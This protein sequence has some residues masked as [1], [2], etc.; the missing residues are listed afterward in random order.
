M[1]Y[2][3]HL[4]SVYLSIYLFVCLSLFL[5]LSVYVCLSLYLSTPPVKV[6]QTAAQELDAR[7]LMFGPL[8]SGGA[9]L[10]GPPRS[11]GWRSSRV[12]W[13]QMVGN[14][15]QGRRI[16]GLLLGPDEAAPDCRVG[17]Q[18]CARCRTGRRNGV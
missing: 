8:A 5:S 14:A 12:S 17:C 1:L 2:I 15:A 18:I 3:E 7:L 10:P 9:P 6:S 13:L 4:L 11:A 16:A